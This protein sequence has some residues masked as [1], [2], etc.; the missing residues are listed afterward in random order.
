VLSGLSREE[1]FGLCVR[2]VVASSATRLSFKDRDGR[3]LLAS[4]GWLNATAPG[5]TLEEVIGKTLEEF[6]NLPHAAAARAADL[7]VLETGE[8]ASPMIERE[9]FDDDRPD[10]WVQITRLPLRS[11][12]GSV[13]GTWAI[14]RDV[15]A[16]VDAE[17]ALVANRE[18]LEASERMHRA[19]FEHNPQPMWLFERE[20]F[21]IFAVND[22]TLA[23]YGY[24]R[25]EF[26]AMRVQELLPPEDV[27]AFASS[28]ELAEGETKTGFRGRVPRR[29]RYKDGT[30]VDVEVTANDVVIDGKAC[31]IVLSQDVTERN[32][33]ATELA[34]ARD[35]AVEAS[36]LKSTFLANISHEIRTPMN[37]VIGMSELLLD[38]A[39]DDD[40]RSLAKQVASSGEQMVLLINDILD[41]SKI[42]A[43][44]LELD[45]T[46]FA[47]RETIEAASAVSRLQAEAKGL[48]LELQIG[49]E[50]PELTHGDGRRLRQILLNLI[51]NAVKFTSKGGITVSAQI[52]SS[53]DDE[54]VLRIEV[55]DTGIGI[56]QA[57]LE[58]MFEPFTQADASTTRNYG[59]SGLGLAIA[60]ELVELMDGSIGAH[61]DMGRGSTFWIELPLREAPA[62]DGAIRVD[63]QTGAP[64]PVW[65][66]VPLVLV[67]DDSPVNQIVAVRTLEHC[68]FQ[69]DVAGDGAEALELL[70]ARHYDAVLMDCEMVG[71][72]GFETTI[73]LRRREN[74]ERHT[75]VIAMTGHAL[76]G[77]RERCLAAGMDDYITKPIRREQLT[78]A[79]GRWIVATDAPQSNNN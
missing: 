63:A 55:A 58:N 52:G 19:L 1:I 72:D 13:V 62:T 79:L 49:H 74:G 9:R 60:R 45:V 4:A 32:A 48:A 77:D 7:R 36:K 64:S 18:E 70:A 46:D 67:A 65:S 15:T 42:E 3:F 35:Q 10:A 66:T 57:I 41:I 27:A 14:I 24:T 33:A 17:Q 6:F 11:D 73:E 78:E 54:I 75:P 50:V 71:M 2:N 61:S 25:E 47:L 44:Q 8:P 56:E 26:L 53:G 20:T 5:R 22:A 34:V 37:G 39:L 43:G 76:H 23:T 16:Q 31:R 21:Q 29:H 30:I 28:M 69:A 51:A 59:G 68:G 12:E 38:T 40:Q